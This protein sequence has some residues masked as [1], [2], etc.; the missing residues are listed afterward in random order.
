MK[1]KNQH[2]KPH[3][4]R[5]TLAKE[6]RTLDRKKQLPKKAKQALK[7]E[8]HSLLIKGRHE[9]LQALEGEQPIE[10]VY[11]S[12]NIRGNFF[13]DLR[14]MVRR[15]GTVMKKMKSDVFKTRFG[16]DCQ[17]VVA[18]GGEFQYCTLE[19]LVELSK[20][21]SGILVALNQ[22][23][24]SRNL[25]AIVRT[26]EASGCDGV[27]IP[28]YRSAGMTE[29]AIRTAQGAASLLP[30]ARVTNLSDSLEQLKDNGYWIIGLDSDGKE[31][32][33]DIR[34]NEK[35]VVVA[36]GENAGLGSRVK[37][38]CDSVVYIPMRGKTT[39]LN[40]SVSAA[41]VLYEILRQ[42]SFLKKTLKK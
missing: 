36:G 15:S 38:V 4:R 14:N 10:A 8:D 22:V 40:V 16:S 18:I 17:G 39:S 28:K 21:K 12:D 42:K 20:T 13:S 6:S 11:I 19:E 32:Y 31:K 25:G 27:I 41:V 33:S 35:V 9:V 37:K 1:K 24:D 2:N 3:S 5:K 34:Y 30:V 26:V 29:W 23:E 7:K